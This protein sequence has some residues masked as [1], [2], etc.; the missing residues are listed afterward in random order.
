M[1][2]PLAQSFTMRIDVKPYVVFVPEKLLTRPKDPMT[3]KP[4]WKWIDNPSFIPYTL[5]PQPNPNPTDHPIKLGPTCPP[6]SEVTVK[7]NAEI[8][9]VYYIH[10]AAYQG[11]NGWLWGNDAFQSQADVDEICF[12]PGTQSTAPGTFSI[13]PSEHKEVIK[14]HTMKACDMQQGW[15]VGAAT[16]MQGNGANLS[17]NATVHETVGCSVND[18]LDNKSTEGCTAVQGFANNSFTTL[19]QNGALPIGTVYPFWN[20]HTGGAP[21]LVGWMKMGMKLNGF[22]AR[23]TSTPAS[24]TSSWDREEGAIASFL[25]DRKIITDAPAKDG[26]QL[27]LAMGVS[28]CAFLTRKPGDMQPQQAANPCKIIKASF[29]YTPGPSGKFK[30]TEPT[31]DDLTSQ[32]DTTVSIWKNFGANK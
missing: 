12:G 32:W 17:F 28:D 13:F 26:P 24:P 15:Q 29:P 23:A 27:K 1:Q 25:T 18:N 20:N 14:L 19:T 2:S 30:S 21:T 6:G 9:I 31:D 4:S 10:S 22:Q 7:Q 3:G 5:F 16:T 11:Q 8:N